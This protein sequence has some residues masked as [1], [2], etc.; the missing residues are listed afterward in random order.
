[1]KG[2]SG[3]NPPGSVLTHQG[4]SCVSVESET[5]DKVYEHNNVLVGW[6]GG[7]SS[8]SSKSKHTWS[9]LVKVDSLVSVK[10]CL[11]MGF[12]KGE[13]WTCD[14]F[15]G[16]SSFT[17]RISTT[18]RSKTKLRNIHPSLGSKKFLRLTQT[19]NLQSR[20]Q[21]IFFSKKGI[22]QKP[23]H[24]GIWGRGSWR[25]ADPWGELPAAASLTSKK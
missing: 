2:S 8:W 7:V 9:N 5:S 25:L 21:L 12:H 23:H 4:S 20:L 16:G 6:R 14:I 10:P 15:P 1:M 22:I 3:H 18:D 17:L 13:D 11:R 24:E 19:H